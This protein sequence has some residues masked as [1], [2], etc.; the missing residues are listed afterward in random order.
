MI[1]DFLEDDGDQIEPSYYVPIIPMLL[2][3]GSEG[4]GTGWSA[5]IPAFHPVHIIDNILG[6]L[7]GKKLEPMHPWYAGFTGT[8]ERVDD[9]RYIS[10]G[11]VQS[12]PQSIR[13]SELPIGKW[14]SD[15]KEFLEDLCSSKKSDRVISSFREHHSEQTVDFQIIFTPL[16]KKFVSTHLAKPDDLD[17]YFKLS[18]PISLTN[19][20]AYSAS[21]R[22]KHYNDPREIL[23]EFIQVRL[24]TYEKRRAAQLAKLKQDHT[25]IQNRC[26]FTQAVVDQS[27]VIFKR[28]KQSVIDQLK[29]MNFDPRPTDTDAE[30]FTY[31]LNTSIFELTQ[32]RIEKLDQEATKLSQQISSL[33]AMTDVKLYKQELRELRASL[34][35]LPQFKK[36]IVSSENQ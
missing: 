6:F 24:K 7:D 30:G 17:A 23:E 2:V 36:S 15:Y 8:V 27:L 1:L 32:E 21:G 22:L 18:K 4:I 28:S 9:Q 33:E 31:L 3:N 29:A 11:C 26:R 12:A 14:T 16:G 19:M 25:K 10:K 34:M 5:S 35:K 13:I 20:H